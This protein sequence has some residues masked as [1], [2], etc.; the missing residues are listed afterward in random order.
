MAVWRCHIEDAAVERL[1]ARAA[2][3]AHESEA[4][5][6]Q[7]LTAPNG[8]K[9]KRGDLTRLSER[10]VWPDVP[11]EV[12]GKT[13]RSLLQQHRVDTRIAVARSRSD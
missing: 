9:P 10:E 3:P 1:A 6:V 2:E 11:P 5:A 13:A 12:L 7:R 4:D 8:Q